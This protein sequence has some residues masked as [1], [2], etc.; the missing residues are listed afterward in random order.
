MTNYRTY[1]ETHPWLTFTLNLAKAS[2]KIWIMLGECQSKCEHM[3]RVP[4]RP[5]TAQALYQ[6][7]MA[8]GVAATTAIEGNTLSEE[9]VLQHLE[10]K[11]TLPPSRQYLGQEI[12][13]VVTGCNRILRE[14]V[15]AKVPELT[16]TG[17]RELNGIVLSKLKLDKDVRPGEFRNYSVGVGRYRGAPP[18]DCEYLVDALCQWLNGG[19]FQGEEGLRMVYA[20]I[21]AVMAHLYIA[22][23]HPFGDGNGRTARLVEFQILIASGVPAASA[24]LLSNHYNLTRSEYYRQLDQASKSGGDVIPF[25]H[26]AVQGLLDGL[27]QQ[28]DK[29]WEQ[30][31]DVIWRNYVHEFFKNDI[32]DSGVRRRHLALDL[33]TR[34]DPVPLEQIAEITPRLAGAYARRTLKTLVRDLNFLIEKGLVEKSAKGYRARCEI[35]LAFQSPRVPVGTV[36][37]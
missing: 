13:N 27:K 32:S 9:E 7:Y 18:E 22:W 1:L 34:K 23:I 20:L 14:I 30:Q 10:G 25:I 3:A 12:D 33:S 17:I 37:R 5:A 4:L 29:I 36:D 15:S 11:L 31:W 16:S 19:D 28:L 21:K 24:H 8:K 26:Y 6:I 35:I 2:P